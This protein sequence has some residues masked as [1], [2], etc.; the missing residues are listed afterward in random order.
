MVACLLGHFVA[1]IELGDFG[2]EVA[3]V[4]DGLDAEVPPGRR[5]VLEHQDMSHGDVFHMDCPHKDI[6]VVLCAT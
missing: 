2:G 1:G 6:P 3:P 4:R 5:W